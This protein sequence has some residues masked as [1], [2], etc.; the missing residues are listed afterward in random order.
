MVVELNYTGE[1]HSKDLRDIVTSVYDDRSGQAE[2][3]SVSG[4][5]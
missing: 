4:D 5:G 1:G 3:C 2:V